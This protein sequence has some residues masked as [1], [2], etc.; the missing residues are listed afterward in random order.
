MYK[1]ILSAVLFC[2]LM[3]LAS[4]R[5]APAPTPTVAAVRN[6]YLN[7]LD[8]FNVQIDRFYIQIKSDPNPAVWQASFKQLRHAYK[9]IEFMFAH[10][11][12]DNVRDFLNGAPLPSIDRVVAELVVY[13]PRGMQAIA[14]ILYGEEPDQ[15]ALLQ[16]TEDLRRLFPGIKATQRNLLFTDRQVLE[17]IRFGIFRITSMGIVGFDTPGYNGA[18][19]ESAISVRAM[20]SAAMLYLPYLPAKH[21]LLADSIQQ[22]FKG[23]IGYLEQNTDFDSF[24]RLECIRKYLEPL[25]GQI[26]RLHLALGIETVEQ[27]TSKSQAL[28]YETPSMF[29]SQTLNTHY[30]AGIG[31][32]VEQPIVVELGKLLFFDPLLSQNNQ[33][34][35]A[36]CHQPQRAFTDGLPKSMSMQKQ[37]D[38]GRNAPTLINSVFA[39]KYFYDLRSDRLESQ[40]EHVIF[41]KAEFNT[42]YYEIID[43]LNQSSTYRQMFQEAFGKAPNAQDISRALTAYVRKLVAFN[44]PVDQYLR[45]API[46]LAPDVQAGFNLF[47]GKALCATCHFVPT[48]AGL[49]PPYFTENESEVIGVPLHPKARQLEIDPDLGRFMNGRP[50]DHA[51]HLRYSFKTTTLRNVALTG[52]YMHNGAYQTLAEVVDF[53]NKGGGAGLGLELPDQTLPFDHLNLTASEQKALVAFMEALT[54][55]TGIVT[56]P[57]KL[58]NCELKPEWNSRKI[59]GQY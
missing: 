38:V 47:M 28:V 23:L 30:Y 9:Q 36:S 33:R 29:S 16:L 50:R 14:S 20:E 24:N 41:N 10:L 3:L 2:T 49:V 32:R 26:L 5:E 42:T 7:G 11:D 52:P 12:P 54:D 58:P 1:L 43:K 59:G 56:I 55:T 40:E 18:I 45:G 22:N 57:A 27:T 15:K 8:S 19:A 13:A 31:S 21:R 46:E 53:Y 48:Y 35:C 25:Y 17:A 51:P 39:D 4:L 44:S 6:A 37:G 34:A